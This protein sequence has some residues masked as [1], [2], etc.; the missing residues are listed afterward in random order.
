MVM[1]HDGQERLESGSAREGRAVT[2]S[3]LN[4]ASDFD[5]PDG[6]AHAGRFTSRYSHRILSGTID[7][8]PQR[9]PREFAQAV[10]GVDLL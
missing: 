2:L 8:L 9:C 7:N 5:S 3:A 6:N 10:T 4:I 1:S